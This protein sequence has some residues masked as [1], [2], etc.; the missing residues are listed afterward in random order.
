MN[1]L[2]ATVLAAAALTLS[3]GIA[4]H[5]GWAWTEDEE[6]RLEGKIVTL[7]D[8]NPHAHLKLRDN[9]GVWEVDLASP[10]ASGRGASPKEPLNRATR[11]S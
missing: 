2:A 8:Q 5:H 9:Q 10:A 7:H 11:P 3:A 4:A 6:S 1:R